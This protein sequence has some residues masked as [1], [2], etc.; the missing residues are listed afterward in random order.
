[1]G[2][3]PD[4]RPLLEQ[5]QHN[6]E[7]GRHNVTKSRTNGFSKYCKYNTKKFDI[8]Y[9]HIMQNPYN[10]TAREKKFCMYYESFLKVR[11]SSTE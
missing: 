8:K 6:I 3:Q 7:K 2:D 1:M 11:N 9:T 4:A 5:G 10:K